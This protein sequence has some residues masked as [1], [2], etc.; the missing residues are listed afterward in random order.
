MRHRSDNQHIAGREIG[1][2]RKR[3]HHNVQRY[4]VVMLAKLV[5]GASPMVGAG[6]TTPEDRA[7]RESR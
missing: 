3:M 1:V 5:T 2:R 4:G 7:L 6:S